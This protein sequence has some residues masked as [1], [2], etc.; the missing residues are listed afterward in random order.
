ML[1]KLNELANGGQ[2][3]EEDAKTLQQ[4]LQQSAMLGI[5]IESI[6][7]QFNPAAPGT[8]QPTSAMS[9]IQAQATEKQKV[10]QKKVK[11]E[12]Q[13][14]KINQ[15]Q[16]AKL[17]QLEKQ[18]QD[19][20]MQMLM[21][22]GLVN[23]A[24]LC[25]LDNE[26]AKLLGLAPATGKNID[27]KSLAGQPG[28]TPEMLALMQFGMNPAGLGN[29]TGQP[30]TSTPKSKSAKKRPATDNGSVKNEKPDSRPASRSSL[31][32]SQR[33]PTPNE[34]KKRKSEEKVDINTLPPNMKIPLVMADGTKMSDGI[35]NKEL[36]GLLESNP[37]IKVG[38]IKIILTFYSH[39]KLLTYLALLTPANFIIFTTRVNNTI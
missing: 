11:T 17:L 22:Q 15:E 24:A 32:S 3:S 14:P 18:L 12:S 20:M 27:P 2:V 33:A 26:T 19:P 7:S 28:M 1:Q 9:Q 29:P 23:P 36:K 10:E 25:G 35:P 37:Q 31:A 39:Q 21:A 34:A 4:I 30:G 38:Q 13:Q 6:M 16:Q 8:P 5:P